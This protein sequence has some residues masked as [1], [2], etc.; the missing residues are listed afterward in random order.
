MNTIQLHRDSRPWVTRRS[1]STNARGGNLYGTNRTVAMLGQSQS[2]LAAQRDLDAAIT[3]AEKTFPGLPVIAW[4]SS[5]SASLVFLAAANHPGEIAKLL[6]FS[7][8]E[9]FSEEYF[10]GEP[11]VA[12]AAQRITIPVF[13]D[14]A[15]DKDEIE[16]AKT[17]LAASPSKL[18][19]QYVPS[20]GIH[21]HRRYAATKTQK[22]MRRTG[23]Q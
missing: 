5:Y 9:Y 8:G 3:W 7:P 22:A 11:A 20:H 21:V 16:A 13:V 15:A 4:G 23:A 12:R 14:S 2:Y 18:K 10:E 1:R 6:A 17:I 19:V